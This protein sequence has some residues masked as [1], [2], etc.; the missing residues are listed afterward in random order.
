MVEPQDPPGK[1]NTPK[2]SPVAEKP[3]LGKPIEL[4]S[5]NFGHNVRDGNVWLIEFYS[6][7]CGHCVEFAP[8]YEDIAR[9]YHAPEN[10][11]KKIRVGKVDGSK[12]RALTSRFNIYGYP[13]FFVVDGWSVYE[14][15]EGRSKRTLSAFV[16]G[17]YRK[18][19]PVPFYHSPMGPVGLVQGYLMYLGLRGIDAFE[20]MVK[21]YKMPPLM[22][23]AIFFGIFF[24]SFFFVIL[25]LA[26]VATPK[27]KTN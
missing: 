12:E 22:T 4:N 17:G 14:F 7:S 24:M 9:T 18:V 10:R 1:Q 2:G 25:C 3:L 15:Q 8:T 13:S 6:P 19:D 5:R 16:E 11:H 20:W 23:G 27:V 26:I 21:E